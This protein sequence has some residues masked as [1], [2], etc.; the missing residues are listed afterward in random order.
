[1]HQIDYIAIMNVN[2]IKDS[3][4]KFLKLDNLIDNLSGYLEARVELVKI[5]LKE[6]VAKLLSRGI[7]YAAMMLFAFLFL[8]FFSI[9]LAHYINSF[10]EAPYAGYWII[11]MIYGVTFLIFL[12]FRKSIHRNFEKHFNEMIQRKEQE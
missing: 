9:G 1:M 10:F 4:F 5:E 8:I 11:S 3:I 7:V 12:L 2:G 6:E